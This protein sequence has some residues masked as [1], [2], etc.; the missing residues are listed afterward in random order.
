MSCRLSVFGLTCWDSALE[1]LGMPR[2][3]SVMKALVASEILTEQNVSR[4][5]GTREWVFKHA[6]VREV[7]YA[8]TR[9]ARTQRAAR[10][11]CSLADVHG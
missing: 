1:S 7:A 8:F 11:G 5:T 2:A 10:A 6:L 4:F 9:R 3:E